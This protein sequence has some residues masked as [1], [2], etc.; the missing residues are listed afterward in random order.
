M[1]HQSVSR[2]TTFGA[3]AGRGATKTG[4]NTYFPRPFPP[5][6]RPD[7]IQ[8]ELSRIWREVRRVDGSKVAVAVK[9]VAEARRCSLSSYRRQHSTAKNVV[10]T[11][12]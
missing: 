2:G 7:M 3:T 8:D 10:L 12:L 6:P 1:N 5:F 11:T 9:N 4:L